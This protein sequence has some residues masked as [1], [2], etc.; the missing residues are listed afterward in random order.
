MSSTVDDLVKLAGPLG[1]LGSSEE[2][3]RL[4]AAVKAG[5]PLAAA[6]RVLGA[7][8]GR[9]PLPPHVERRTFE[10]EAA[11]LLNDLARDASVR[12]ELGRAL[13]VQASRAVALDAMAL[14]ADQRFGP[15]LA[16]LVRAELERPNLSEHEL[17]SLASALGAVAGDEASGLLQQLRARPYPATVLREIDVALSS[18]V[19]P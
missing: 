1:P 8:A 3:D 14:S 18:V 10:F 6:Q 15:A 4:R 17:I 19:S 16:A 13:A 7:V 2:N 12:L 9:P 5:D 11:E